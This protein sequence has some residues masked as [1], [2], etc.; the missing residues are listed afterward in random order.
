MDFSRCDI[1]KIGFYELIPV[2]LR[3]ENVAIQG[4]MIMMMTMINDDNDDDN[5]K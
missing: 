4:M 2:L 1:G 5:D 3:T